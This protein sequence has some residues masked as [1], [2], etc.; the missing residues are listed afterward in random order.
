MSSNIAIG[1][2][3]NPISVS[4]P[5]CFFTQK[6]GTSERI[7]QSILQYHGDSISSQFGIE[8]GSQSPYIS[9]SIPSRSSS[10]IQSIPSNQT[11]F[12]LGTVL[13]VL[14]VLPKHRILSYHHMHTVG[15]TCIGYHRIINICIGTD[16]N[17]YQ[18]HAQKLLFPSASL[19]TIPTKL[20]PHP[21]SV[22]PISTHHTDTQFYLNP[23]P[24]KT[25]PKKSIQIS[26]TL[27]KLREIP[28]K[29][30]LLSISTPLLRFLRSK[31]HLP[32]RRARRRR[33]P[34]G[35]S[36][37]APQ[38]RRVQRG[39]QQLGDELRLQPEQ[40]FALRDQTW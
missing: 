40:G 39:V 19:D 31:D 21:S 20:Y 10:L 3:P 29:S 17:C 33:Q 22:G 2:S 6:M 1:K 5:A 9:I 28:S 23:S 37:P 15:N 34:F 16:G 14:P 38:R 24:K 27:Q 4:N 25:H 8:T 7:V 11:L 35:Q 12:F 26:R 32:R 36:R 18:P 13:P 30:H